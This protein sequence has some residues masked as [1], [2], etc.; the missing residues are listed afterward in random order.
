MNFFKTSALTSIAQASNIIIGFISIKIVAVHIGAEGL[1]HTGQ[2][3][4]FAAIVTILAG[5]GL[6]QALVKQIAESKTDAGEVKSVVSTTLR[7]AVSLTFLTALVLTCFNE[8]LSVMLFNTPVYSDVLPYWSAILVFS[9]L[10]ASLLSVLNGLGKIKALTLLG[11]S[12]NIVTLGATIGLLYLFGIKGVMLSPYVAAILSLCVSLLY[13][14]TTDRETYQLLWGG[15]WN[16]KVFRTSANIM[17]MATIAAIILPIVHIRIRKE[18]L[19]NLSAADA[20]LWQAVTRLSD[21]YLGFGSSVLAVYFLPKFASIKSRE[22]LRKEVVSA[23]RIVV[24]VVIFL[25][26]LIWLCRDLI[27]RIV[28][29]PEFAA[30]RNLFGY[31]L[32]GD[33]I[34]IASWILGYILWAKALRNVFLVTEIFFGIVYGT[35]SIVLAKEVGLIGTVMSFPIAYAF[36]YTTLAVVLRRKKVI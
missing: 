13:L 9:I 19:A 2:F 11:I 25:S 24:P 12:N 31:Q 6:G 28:F 35:L 18:I 5:N 16:R 32:F 3:N 22:L 7:M 4:S 20:G 36:Y 10:H 33:V 34:K 14:R 26:L 30:A 27:L 21:Y 17:A 29:T 23:H 1:G 8:Q 15:N